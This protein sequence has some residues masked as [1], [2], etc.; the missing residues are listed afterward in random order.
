M[1][2]RLPHFIK[3]L[4]QPSGGFFG[5][6]IYGKSE[7]MG[8]VYWAL[9]TLY[10]LGELDKVNT[11][12]VENW[13]LSCRNEDGSYKEKPGGS[14]D[15]CSTCFA[16]LSLK[17]LGETP[18]DLS[19]SISYIV[20]AQQSDG[21]WDEPHAERL[22]HGTFLALWTLKEYNSLAQADVPKAIEF[23]KGL[24]ADDGGFYENYFNEGNRIHATFSAIVSLEVFL[25]SI[26]SIDS[27]K[28]LQWLK[29]QQRNDGGFPGA[30][31]YTFVAETAEAMITAKTLGQ[32]NAIDYDA[33]YNYVI[34]HYIEEGDIAYWKFWNDP[35]LDYTARSVFVYLGADAHSI[36]SVR[37]PRTQ[38]TSTDIQQAIDKGILW[39]INKQSLDGGWPEGGYGATRLYNTWWA[40]LALRST[41]RDAKYSSAISKALDFI[42]K[43]AAGPEVIQLL[44]LYGTPTSDPIIQKGINSILEKQN[45]D[46]SWGKNDNGEIT[47]H[48]VWA[49]ALAGYSLTS[50]TI[51]KALNYIYTKQNTDGGWILPWTGTG[52]PGVTATIVTKLLLSGVPASDDHVQKALNYIKAKQKPS[53]GW[54]AAD[55]YFYIEFTAR[56]LTALSLSGEKLDSAPIQ[57]GV[58]FLL[59][60]RNTDGSFH[61]YVGNSAT[62]IYVTADVLSSLG[63][64]LYGPVLPVTKKANEVKV[65]GYIISD[66]RHEV[67]SNRDIWY[68]DVGINEVLVD[69]TGSLHAGD[70]VF[71]EVHLHRGAQLTGFPKSGPKKGD[72]VEVYGY[73]FGELWAEQPSHYMKKIGAP[74]I[75]VELVDP[76]PPDG[77]KVTPPI[78]FRARVTSNGQPVENAVVTFYME[79][80]GTSYI[81][82]SNIRTDS[83]GY[84]EVKNWDPKWDHEVTFRWWAEAWKEGYEK[85]ASEKR[86]LTYILP[87]APIALDACLALDELDK[88]LFNSAKKVDEKIKHFPIKVASSSISLLVSLLPI[89]ITE[90][91]IVFMI[92]GTQISVR[93]NDLI[94]FMIGRMLKISVEKVTEHVIEE[95]AKDKGIVDLYLL[96]GSKETIVNVRK[97]LMSLGVVLAKYS[98][99]EKE[100]FINDLKTYISFVKNVGRSYSDE[101]DKIIIMHEE[102]VFAG[103]V[104]ITAGSIG[105]MVI[106]SSV[107]LPF[108]ACIYIISGGYGVVTYFLD[109][110]NEGDFA[111]TLINS[112]FSEVNDAIYH[113]N[114]IFNSLK[115]VVNKLEKKEPFPMIKYYFDK[116][117]K[118]VWIENVGEVPVRIRAM[119]NAT[120][121]TDPLEQTYISPVQ[122]YGGFA[123]EYELNPKERNT[124]PLIRPLPDETTKEWLKKA[125]NFG[126]RVHE[127]GVYTVEYSESGENA[128][129]IKLV[130]MSDTY[131]PYSFREK[132][133][134][135]FMKKGTAPGPV[136]NI[137]ITLIE[138]EHKLHL[139][140]YDVQG[141]Y[142][143]FNPEIESVEVNI[144]D[145][146]YLDFGNMTMV[147]LPREIQIQKV[148]VDSSK[149][150]EVVEKYNLSVTVFNEG[151]VINSMTISSSIE[152]N[153]YKEY[154]VS[155]TSDL[156]PNIKEITPLPISVLISLGILI[157]IAIII[158]IIMITIKRKTII[159]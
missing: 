12:A 127:F 87:I 43:Q 19:A 112:W 6:F 17:I 61:N 10:L 136:N 15:V 38:I 121:M 66:P 119:Y 145:S 148:I 47:A 39:L 9:H 52:D 157:I 67:W 144:P 49:L 46:G 126:L 73:Y 94:K 16:L 44:I 28:A 129:A 55:G 98:A 31:G 149:A 21:G 64:I 123:G 30:G 79:N 80:G 128:F 60:Y 120:L 101:I 152:K 115:Y 107:S 86:T 130:P 8:N 156:K 132:V 58:S 154:K 153:T 25:N 83:N 18:P 76:S 110:K 102:E 57:K 26:T 99:V 11:N 95:L 88:G 91:K 13:I 109:L 50:D 100:E 138:Q 117:N 103:N 20:N 40:M 155:L 124:I 27:A 68:F 74:K 96:G 139:R 92:D 63:T 65:R 133:E 84:V 113:T 51:K 141:R 37:A 62:E 151:K 125:T 70:K 158:A 135:V 122:R 71:V 89:K 29:N 34:S 137:V 97:E 93:I 111:M 114:R 5:F 159:F 104:L 69:P 116:Q 75:D 78:T 32:P 150:K 108:T 85:G 118:L 53:G 42:K 142:M 81:G 106:A 1:W 59:T 14:A 56:C 77:A 36:Y 54:Q 134:S 7:T 105:L 90:S 35:S 146:Y 45:K 23:I 72:Y 131:E 2:Q 22:T 24:Q 48:H 143:G 41:Q 140:V 82:Q 4:Q 147:I 33:A 3:S